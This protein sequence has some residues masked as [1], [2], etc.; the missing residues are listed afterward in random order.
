[1]KR[2]NEETLEIGLLRI[3][4][5]PMASSC[6]VSDLDVPSFLSF[7]SINKSF[8]RYQ[9]S[10]ALLLAL[11]CRLYGHQHPLIQETVFKESNWKVFLKDRYYYS[12][13]R[14]LKRLHKGF[15][16]VKGLGSLS[17]QETYILVNEVKHNLEMLSYH[18]QASQNIVSLEKTSPLLPLLQHTSFTSFC[19][20]F[21]K[22]QQ[23][24]ADLTIKNEWTLYSPLYGIPI[25]FSLELQMNLT[26]GDPYN[27]DAVFST[28]QK[29]VKKGSGRRKGNVVGNK[30][31]EKE[32]EA[33]MF[34]GIDE[35][36]L[37]Q[38]MLFCGF[39]NLVEPGDEVFKKSLVEISSQEDLE[40]IYEKLVIHPCR[41]M[42]TRHH[43]MVISE[44]GLYCWG[45]N[46]CG[47]LGLQCQTFEVPQLL[48]F[49]SRVIQTAQ[50]DAHSL[51]LL[52]DHSLYACGFNRS[53]Q[54]GTG[55]I[56]QHEEPVKVRPI[57]GD[58]IQVKCGEFHSLALTSDGSLY[59]W[60][61][62]QLGQLGLSEEKK[63]LVPTKVLAAP[64]GLKS[65]DCWESFSMGLTRDGT[66]Y[67]WGC[68][69]SG[70]LGL[71]VKGAPLLPTPRRVGIE[72]VKQ[73]SCGVDHVLALLETGELYGWGNGECGQLGIGSSADM[74]VPTQIMSI[75]EEISQVRCGPVGRL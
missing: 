64:P 51:F 50:G 27:F 23:I 29:D 17:L 48:T 38:Y 13:G 1:M 8:I 7:T 62:N 11:Y 39:A 24:Q 69:R 42:S 12:Q 61:S 35:R 40:Q 52:I 59:A 47:Q 30:E 10:K 22:I 57:C 44:D 37:G 75:P 6:L 14:A 60:G 2:K 9:S 63:L 55:D 43:L 31:K 36:L 18:Q 45:R 68:N 15:D 66:L 58:V 56:R 67:G 16:E 65:I 33:L 74:H 19:Y 71:G 53:G 21:N 25:P 49:P 54:L 73:F 4:E 46:K 34:K 20:E 41:R 28:P 5:L 3:M 32:M 26:D 72:E 70:Q